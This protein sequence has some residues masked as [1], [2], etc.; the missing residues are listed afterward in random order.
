[1]GVKLVL[2]LS[3]VA[4]P[5]VV[6]PFVHLGTKVIWIPFYPCGSR[7]IDEG[8]S[9]G[10]TGTQSPTD[11]E[12][13]AMCD[14]LVKGEPPPPGFVMSSFEHEIARTTGVIDW[15][16]RHE[17]EVTATA[18][19]DRLQSARLYLDDA[20]VSEATHENGGVVESTG[21]AK[22]ALRF[23]L[24]W[25]APYTVRLVKVGADGREL[26][27]SRTVGHARPSSK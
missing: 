26:E 24:P 5:L 9:C 13:A 12:M 2:A 20:L 8:S 21:E 4:T 16:G 25:L 15:F 22:A 27:S 6:V 18:P 11:Q 1:M 17:V 19:A 7:T 23:F 10:F 3:V 14:A